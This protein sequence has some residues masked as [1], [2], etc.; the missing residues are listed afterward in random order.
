MKKLLLPVVM[1]AGLCAAGNAADIKS[2]PGA[3]TS[4]APAAAVKAPKS[5]HMK[6]KK[7]KKVI[8]N[9]DNGKEIGLAAGETFQVSLP[10]NP[11]TGYRWMVYGSTVSFISLENDDYNVPKQGHG[12]PRLGQG[13]TR[14]L[15]FL[16]AQPGETQLILRLRRSWEKESDF[17]EAFSVKL[18]ISEAAKR[19]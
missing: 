16:A 6:P 13:G 15:T 18:K 10:E 7:V 14:L 12:R 19:P 5:K 4:A 1:C 9:K 2:A 11:T 17:A 8:T 3:Q